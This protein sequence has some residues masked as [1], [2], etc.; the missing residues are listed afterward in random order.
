MQEEPLKTFK[1]S[2]DVFSCPLC[3]GLFER[4]LTLACGHT[5]CRH[6]LTMKSRVSRKEGEEDKKE[7]V[8][9][10]PSCQQ[11]IWRSLWP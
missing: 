9:L 8:P 4:P 7:I 10:C 3:E 6:C 1:P 5:F 11:I 2:Q